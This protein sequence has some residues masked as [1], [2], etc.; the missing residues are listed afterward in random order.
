MSVLSGSMMEMA[1]QK[2]GIQS[3]LEAKSVGHM[4]GLAVRHLSM[5]NMPSTI[6]EGGGQKTAADSC[7]KSDTSLPLT[8][9]GVRPVSVNSAKSAV[10]ANGHPVDH[11][12]PLSSVS[13]SKISNSCEMTSASATHD[14]SCSKKMNEGE[15]ASKQN[16]ASVCR[17]CCSKTISDGCGNKML[18]GQKIIPVQPDTGCAL[19]AAKDVKHS[20]SKW[21]CCLSLHKKDRIQTSGSSSEVHGKASVDGRFSHGKP[22]SSADKIRKHAKKLA[23]TKTSSFLSTTKWHVT[24]YFDADGLP[25][26]HDTVRATTTW[27]VTDIAN[28]SSDAAGSSGTGVP[29]VQQSDAS[30]ACNE[31]VRGGQG[32]VVNGVSV[33]HNETR[34]EQC[35]S[36]KRTVNCTYTT[37][38]I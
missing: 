6:S 13:K 36:V 2:S 23:A 3:G 5:P 9:C 34:D 21:N 12:S 11:L 31:A 30:A 35:T 8:V 20:S 10:T 16:K 14:T 17:S 4:N 33:S 24:R 32:H 19:A 29:A 26:S 1:T 18:S 27:H 28:Q 37:C 22:V 25:G 38:H 7:R 15:C